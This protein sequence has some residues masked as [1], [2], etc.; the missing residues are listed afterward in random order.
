VRLV[1]KLLNKTFITIFSWKII[2]KSGIRRQASTSRVVTP[3]GPHSISLE[4][5][6]RLACLV[7]TNETAAA[8]PSTVAAAFS[9]IIRRFRDTNHVTRFMIAE[10][11]IWFVFAQYVTNVITSLLN[12]YY[13][14]HYS[15]SRACWRIWP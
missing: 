9:F 14:T 7:G 4:R 6:G 8:E 5:D 12:R 2:S 13:Y 15:T 10:F 3:T 1:T 11:Q